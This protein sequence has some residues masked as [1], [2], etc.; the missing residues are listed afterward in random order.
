VARDGIEPP[1][2]RFSDVQSKTKKPEK[3]ADSLGDRRD[4]AITVIG[5]YWLK[6]VRCGS[7]QGQF[8]D[9]TEVERWRPRREPLLVTNL[10]SK[11]F[12]AQ[13]FER[14]NNTVA[15][16]QHALDFNQRRFVLASC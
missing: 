16:S 9:I 1:T 7:R 14:P 12:G 13:I 15:C 6:L 3:Y 4:Q 10:F 8:R 5:C 11:G 2:L